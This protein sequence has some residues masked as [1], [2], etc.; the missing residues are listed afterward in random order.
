MGGRIDLAA[1]GWVLALTLSQDGHTLGRATERGV[2]VWDVDT[3]QER[4]VAAREVPRF[5]RVGAALTADGRRLL[6]VG[7]ASDVGLK[8]STSIA[9]PG[10]TAG[11]K[12]L[13]PP[14]RAAPGR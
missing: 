12:G 13:R 3:R 9:A 8:G 1:P 6:V 10:V 14:G 11:S 4:K 7:V 2:A 5:S